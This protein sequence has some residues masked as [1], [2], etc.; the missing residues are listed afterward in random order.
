MANIKQLLS[1]WLE[2]YKFIIFFSEQ[3]PDDRNG[4]Y[5]RAIDTS[6]ANDPQILML[7]LTNNN[8]EKYV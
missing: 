8:E 5:S 3:M 6:A 1:F 7:V 4:S 2:Y